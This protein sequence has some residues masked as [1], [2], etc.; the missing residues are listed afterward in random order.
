MPTGNAAA[1]GGPMTFEPQSLKAGAGGEMSF[2]QN[3]K[4][5]L[6]NNVQAS[7]YSSGGVDSS[8]H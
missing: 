6:N 7:M 8:F 3:S 4:G 1:A 5:V 2:N